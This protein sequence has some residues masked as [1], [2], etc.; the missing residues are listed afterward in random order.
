MAT[1]KNYLNSI[2]LSSRTVNSYHQSLLNFT[3]YCDNQ[4]IELENVHHGEVLGYIQ[5][6]KSKGLKQRSI[7]HEISS[8]KHYYNWLI[9]RE[10]TTSN[11]I[12][13]IKIKG[14]QRHIL[15]PIL[16]TRELD[17]IYASYPTESQTDKR[18]K[19]ISGLII[20]QG[21]RG[22]EVIQMS[23]KNIDLRAGKIKVEGFRRSEART[24]D[25]QVVQMMD[26][27]EY[28]M[29][30]RPQILKE[31]EKESDIFIVSAGSGKYHQNAIYNVVKKIKR[32]NLKVQNA[33]QIH[34]SVITHWVKQYNLRKAQYMAGHRYVSSTE[35]YLIND[36]E[37]LQDAMHHYH[38]GN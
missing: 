4:N 2:G 18:D 9:K 11:P 15:Y 3:A 7:A 35:R 33:Q 38:P 36:M 22:D 10:I 12:K 13:N 28:Q 34:A 29:Q 5:H 8:L 25:I 17:Q 16:N 19:V 14:I 20:Y 1:Y 6:L 37:G 24:L 23:L 27:M 32:Q 26:I 30:V 21:L 31:A